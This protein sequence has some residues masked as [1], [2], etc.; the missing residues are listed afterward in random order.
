MSAHTDTSESLKKVRGRR[1]VMVHSGP[2]GTKTT[3]ALTTPCSICDP[4]HGACRVETSRLRADIERFKAA[5]TRVEALIRSTPQDDPQDPHA[6]VIQ[7]AALR[8]AL[9]GQGGTP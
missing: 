4:I 6:S 3:H 1:A 5:V 8:C 7:V 9:D 2:Y